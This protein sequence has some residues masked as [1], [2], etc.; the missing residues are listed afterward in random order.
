MPPKRQIIDSLTEDE[1]TIMAVAV[2]LDSALRYREEHMGAVNA[3]WYM[4][5]IREELVRRTHISIGGRTLTKPLQTEVNDIFANYPL[6]EGPRIHPIVSHIGQKWE[7]A[8]T[9]GKTLDL[10]TLEF[11]DVAEQCTLGAAE[12]P[13]WSG[14]LHLQELGGLLVSQPKAIWWW[15]PP[16]EGQDDDTGAVKPLIY[17]IYLTYLLET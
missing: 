12:H 16:T 9:Q 11:S 7:D 10:D 3:Q 14:Q 1:K 8:E 13:T 2:R 17:L 15:L 6:G 5:C 4:K